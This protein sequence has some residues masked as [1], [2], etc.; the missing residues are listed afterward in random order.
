[1]ISKFIN[2]LSILIKKHF[3]LLPNSKFI[4]HQLSNLMIFK[5]HTNLPPNSYQSKMI[6][7]EVKHCKVKAPPCMKDPF[8]K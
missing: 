3:N 6:K 7:Y 5:N 1:M 8:I 2:Q 4:H